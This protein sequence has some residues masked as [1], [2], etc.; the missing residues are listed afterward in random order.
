MIFYLVFYI[1]WLYKYVFN[2]SELEFKIIHVNRRKT[3][4][5]KQVYDKELEI[6]T[7]NIN[8]HNK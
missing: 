7:N 6:L 3:C 4:D 8:L 2:E 5:E 1:I